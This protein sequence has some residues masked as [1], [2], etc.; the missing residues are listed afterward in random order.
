MGTTGWHILR[1]DRAVTVA[2]HLPPRLD[3]AVSARIEASGPV[4]LTALAHQVRQDV[5]RAVQKV[6][7]FSP[8]VRVGQTGAAIELEVGGRVD[9]AAG[10]AA[11]RIAAVLDSAANRR[12]W[13]TH[14]GRRA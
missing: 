13:L 3:V 7:G 8:V 1:E 2:R 4:S 12:R 11:D 5:W 6:R 9:G 14:A 10:G